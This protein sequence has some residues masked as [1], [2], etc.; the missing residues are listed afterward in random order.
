MT[1]VNL[2]KLQ[3]KMKKELDADRYQHTLGVM[4]TAASLAMCYGED[5][6]KAQL[7]GLLHDC[8]KCIPNDKKLKL[9]SKY[10]LEVSQLER[11]TPSLLHARLGAELARDEYGIDDEEII[12]AI[13]WHTT[14]K[15][16]M[17]LLEK[18]IYVADYIEPMR[19][20]ADRLTE[21]RALSF[22][23]LDR[24]VYMTMEDTLAYL[25]SS[26]DKVDPVTREAFEYY[27]GLM[28]ER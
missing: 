26:T 11:E 28:K 4:F 27:S 1:S 22:S 17:T 16:E 2:V 10:H 15:P 25:Q 20:K 23:D 3:R 12:S 21:I 9:C 7:A 13:C 14:G 8:A 18:I 24:A 6:G 19:W 5:V